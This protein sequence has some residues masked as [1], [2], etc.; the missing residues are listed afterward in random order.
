MSTSEIITHYA[1]RKLEDQMSYSQIRKELMEKGFQMEEIS[2]MI[3]EMDTEVL[4]NQ[5]IKSSKKHGKEMYYLGSLL[6]LYGLVKQVFFIYAYIAENAPFG[7]TF[8]PLLIGIPL[9]AAG[10]NRMK[11]LNRAKGIRNIR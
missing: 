4:R 11:Q 9:M 6:V 1:K 3:S 8:I 5:N 2:K 10:K 7:F